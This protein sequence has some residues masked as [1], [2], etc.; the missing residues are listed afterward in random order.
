VLDW[1]QAY[2]GS[3]SLMARHF[4]VTRETVGILKKK[5]EKHG[6]AGLNNGNHR[7]KTLQTMVT[8]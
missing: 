2:Q 4:G 5:F 1:L 6:I 8:S 3:V 7:P